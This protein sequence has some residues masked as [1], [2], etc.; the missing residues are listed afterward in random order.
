DCHQRPNAAN[1]TATLT[2]SSGNDILYVGSA[3]DSLTGGS[4]AD[5]FAWTLADAGA[6]GAPAVDTIS[7]F[8][9]ASPSAGG[10]LLDLRDLLQGE[11]NAALDKYL[12]FDTSSV[13]GSTV[14]HISSSGGFTAGA[15]WDASHAGSENQR[16]VLSGV[17]LPNALGL[18]GG[19][20]E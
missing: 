16:I 7:D 2:G 9:V 15:T 17:D 13:P 20:S 1:C 5:V 19:A 14:I 10:D 12:E 4:G 11:S 18:A 3:N 6:K 8:N